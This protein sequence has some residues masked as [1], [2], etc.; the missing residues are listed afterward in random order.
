MNQKGQKTFKI[1]ISIMVLL[2]FFPG[3][4]DY[5][6]DYM[7]EKLVAAYEEI[8]DDLYM[9]NRYERIEDWQDREI[10]CLGYPDYYEDK[11]FVIDFDLMI[12][13]KNQ[14]VKSIEYK[15]DV[16]NYWQISCETEIRGQGDCE[17]IAIMIW[18]GLRDAGFPDNI[19]GIGIAKN[20]R[21]QC[22]AFAIVYYTEKDF[23]ILDSNFWYEAIKSDQLD[24]S[25]TLVMGCNLFSIWE[26]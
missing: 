7:V 24:N 1:I 18:K 14:V 21:G 15:P 3:C 26:F 17:D 13:I 5:I 12:W 22:H 6:E 10:E 16:T 11:D 20:D 23:Y 2:I 9:I 19:I 8:R 25:I 4:G